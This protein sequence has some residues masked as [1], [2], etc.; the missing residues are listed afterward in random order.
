MAERYTR[1]FMLPETDLYETGAPLLICEGALL[2]DTQTGRMIAQLK[3][4]NI[5][6][7]PITAVKVSVRAFDAFGTEVKSVPEFQYLDLSVT[8][9]RE[10]GQETPIV[11]PNAETRSFSCACQ[12]VIFSDGTKWESSL[13]EWRPLTKQESLETRFGNLAAQY[14]RDT[15]YPFA[16]YA[17]AED[18]DLWLCACGAVN[19]AD[20]TTC[21]VCKLN[22]EALKAAEAPDKLKEHD[23]AY[24]KRLAKQ[25]ES[26]NIV[27]KNQ[28]RQTLLRTSVLFTRYLW[29]EK[30]IS[31][32]RKREEN[33]GAI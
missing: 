16:K 29:R 19:H 17:F 11:L 22:R 13:D 14:R 27:V 30:W 25:A 23:E 18:R 31:K 24:Q 28:V 21:H 10:F 26:D 7:K 12:G 5:G 33:A 8:R 3:F 6:T 1:V 32:K 9:D 15:Y 4:R 20:E 2:K